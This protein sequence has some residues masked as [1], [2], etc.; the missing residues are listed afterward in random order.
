MYWIIPPLSSSGPSRGV[1]SAKKGNSLICLMSTEEFTRKPSRVKESF[2]RSIGT[3]CAVPNTLNLSTA[4]LMG[5]PSGRSG[6]EEGANRCS[7]TSYSS[8]IAIKSRHIVRFPGTAL[9]YSCAV[10]FGLV[11][12]VVLSKF[13]FFQRL[14]LF[15]GD[16]LDSS[17]II[18]RYGSTLCAAV[19]AVTSS[20]SLERG[21]AWL[22]IGGGY[23]TAKVSAKVSLVSASWV[24]FRKS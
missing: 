18:C 1:F 20:T 12:G 10:A 3:S 8:C 16:S 9:M 2:P 19:D 5:S 14:L 6:S 21:G 7:G 23:G 22:N 24:S 15:T 11:F 17:C 4:L 13:T